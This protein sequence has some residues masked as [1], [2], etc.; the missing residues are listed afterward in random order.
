MSYK[1]SINI[2]YDVIKEFKIKLNKNSDF[3][4]GNNGYTTF[5]PYTIHDGC[6]LKHIPS[7]LAQQISS[8]IYKLFGLKFT[9]HSLRI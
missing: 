2:V 4:F 6:Y 5:N 1:E 9:G 7:Y 3:I 8:M